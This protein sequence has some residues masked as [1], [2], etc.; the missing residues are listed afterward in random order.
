MLHVRFR[1]K[2]NMSVMVKQR[3]TVGV[4]GAMEGEGMGYAAYQVKVCVE[5]ETRSLEVNSLEIISPPP[6]ILRRRVIALLRETRLARVCVCVSKHDRRWV[7]IG[8]LIHR[9]ISN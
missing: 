3:S 7:F 2:V 4:F 5:Q 9:T 6:L 1:L 8:S